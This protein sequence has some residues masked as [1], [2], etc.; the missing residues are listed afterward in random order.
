[1][2]HSSTFVRIACILA[3]NVDITARCPGNSYC[4]TYV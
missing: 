2:N 1:M 3:A 4:S